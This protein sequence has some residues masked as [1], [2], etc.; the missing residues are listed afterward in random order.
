LLIL[1][2]PLAERFIAFFCV[3]KGRFDYPVVAIAETPAIRFVVIPD[4]IRAIADVH[5][6]CGAS[7]AGKKQESN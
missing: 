3:C 6:F 2:F 4:G 7:G 5:G 1:P